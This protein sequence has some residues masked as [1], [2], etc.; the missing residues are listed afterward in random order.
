MEESQG[1]S[2]TAW[3]GGGVPT[4]VRGPA[5]SV[6]GKAHEAPGVRDRAMEERAEERV[7]VHQGE[8]PGVSG[9]AAKASQ[10][11]A[12]SLHSGC[13]GEKRSAMSCVGGELRD[14]REWL[15]VASSRG[16]VLGR[17]EVTARCD[18]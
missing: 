9:K 11:C 14:V 16:V 7:E 6:P 2:S 5:S 1:G 18:V 15:D 3:C 4:D 8:L 10:A 12:Y 17:V 13:G